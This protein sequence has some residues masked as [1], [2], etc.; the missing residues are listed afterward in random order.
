MGKKPKKQL[1]Y[2][3]HVTKAKDL[4]RQSVVLSH[5]N[6]Y[7]FV[8]CVTCGV[9]R[10]PSDPM[11]HCGHFIHARNNVYFLLINAN[12]Q[13]AQCNGFRKGMPR[14]YASYIASRHGADKL[15]W[16]LAQAKVRR[17]FTRR[18]LDRIIEESRIIIRLHGANPCR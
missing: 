2:S 16:L 13:C 15:A 9:Q 10:Q 5:Q 3:A 14:E 18:F 17:D 4:W 6:E 7:G 11:M 1:S 8:K 12:P